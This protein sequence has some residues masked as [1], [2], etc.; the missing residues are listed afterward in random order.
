MI[1][2]NK[3]VWGYIR[4][5]SKDQNTERQYTALSDFEKANNI[6]IERIF[7]DKISGKTF[8]RDGF[9]A[10][11]MVLRKGDILI[12]KELDR[13]GRDMEQIKKEW[14]EIQNKGVDIVVLD[15]PMLNT[16]NKNDLEKKLI[17]SIVFELLAYLAEKER[18]KIKSRQREGI[19]LAKRRGVYTGRKPIE[20]N[21]KLM[22]EVCIKWRGGEITAREA[23]K[24]VNLEA[25]TFYR[26]VKQMGL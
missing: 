4:V 2:E 26:R 14:Q 20:I 9:N 8:N 23:M 18:I 6:Q 5:S 16:T 7:E 13:L 12:I 15:T 21:E 17:S 3:K 11:K 10:L 24:K 1:E 22:K 19:E 25:N